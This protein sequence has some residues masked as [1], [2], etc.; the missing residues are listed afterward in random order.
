MHDQRFSKHTLRGFAILWEKLSYRPREK[1]AMCYGKTDHPRSVR[2]PTFL[3]EKLSY[4]PREKEA[5][6]YG[7]TDHPRSVRLPTFFF[8]FFFLR[9]Q[10]FQLLSNI[11]NQAFFDF[12]QK[13]PILHSFSKLK[14]QI[15][16]I[17]KS[18]SVAP[19]KTGFSFFRGLNTHSAPLCSQK[20]DP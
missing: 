3:W 13:R 11:F 8:S 4:R 15:S 18:G 5:M 16:R 14:K 9:K 10:D 1:E 7:K 2:L 19:V 12:D 20:L 17:E 6:C